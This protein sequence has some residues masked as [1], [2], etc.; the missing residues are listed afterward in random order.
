[1]AGVLPIRQCVSVWN[2]AVAAWCAW[3]VAGGASRA[4]VALRRYQIVRL[5]QSFGRRSPW[6]LS[7]DDLGVWLASHEWGLES[8]RSYRS[9]VRSF[10]GWAHASGKVESDPSR[11]LRR[12]RRSAPRPR[13]APEPVID[14]A[15]AAADGR[16]RLMLLLGS[17]EGLRRGEIALIRGSDVT[18][19]DAGWSLLV[20]GKG[21]KER[22][23]PLL[24]EIGEMLGGAGPGWAF[25]NGRGGHLSPGHVSV[26]LRRSLGSCTAHQLRHRFGTVAY[27]RSHD[28]RAVQ[29][30]LGHASVATTQVYTAIDLAA[31]RA[32]VNSAA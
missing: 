6:S 3:L 23:V 26:I 5:G 8:L 13:P 29:E 16:A 7:P 1:M 2:A 15:L 24:D 31:L 30:L 22:T 11:L 32:A 9:A 19:D 14:A 4:T 27:Q 18:R 21:G 17:R 10:Y 25:P 12:V 20:H 28:I